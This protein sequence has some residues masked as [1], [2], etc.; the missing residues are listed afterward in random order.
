MHPPWRN[1]G[2]IL[3]GKDVSLGSIGPEAVDLNQIVRSTNP[4]TACDF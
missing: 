2:S 1:G 3:E 4:V